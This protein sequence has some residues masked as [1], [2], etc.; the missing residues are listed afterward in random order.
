MTSTPVRQPGQV[1]HDAIEYGRADE[2]RLDL[3]GHLDL[4]DEAAPEQFLA[5]E[6][7]EHAL[8]FVGVSVAG[9]LG[10]SGRRRSAEGSPGRAARPVHPLAV[11][12]RRNIWG[13]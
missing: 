8:G 1:A 9:H 11:D 12:I 2:S 7:H 6:A 5:L 3:H 10:R 4:A 13:A